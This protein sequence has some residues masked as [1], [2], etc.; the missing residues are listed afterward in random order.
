MSFYLFMT[1]VISA[2][3]LGFSA[4]SEEE[5]SAMSIILAAFALGLLWPVFIGCL[6][7]GLI[8]AAKE[9]RA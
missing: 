7:Y 2:W 4:G 1:A 6:L 9:V 5:S 8:K 3:S